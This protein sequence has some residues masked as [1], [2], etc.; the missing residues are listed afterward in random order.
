MSLI[1]DSIIMCLNGR[2]EPTY[3]GKNVRDIYKQFQA[4]K[5]KLKLLKK[6]S[7]LIDAS[8]DNANITNKP[9]KKQKKLIDKI[10]QE[11]NIQ[12]K[13]WREVKGAQEV[14]ST[15][16]T[17]LNQENKKLLKMI[18]IF[19]NKIEKS[20]NNSKGFKVPKNLYK[21]NNSIFD[22]WSKQ[23][24]K[25]I[26]AYLKRRPEADIEWDYNY[27]LAEKN[28]GVTFAR[29][30][31]LKNVPKPL[32][33][34]HNTLYFVLSQTYQT[35]NPKILSPVHL[36]VTDIKPIS[37][38]IKAHPIKN[39]KDIRN[40]LKYYSNRYNIAL[41]SNENKVNRKKE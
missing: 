2:K 3:K 31:P 10:D 39:I 35:K 27:Y 30:Y 7:V 38:N 25:E 36:A 18:V 41:W 8:W 29:V 14:I 21:G 37:T 23:V 9:I 40:A 20:K 17:F 16:N 15:Y 12:Y 34:K 28:K 6:E 32:G 19:S 24:N 1:A 33:G 26:K 5:K 22:I 13:K 11:V 4:A